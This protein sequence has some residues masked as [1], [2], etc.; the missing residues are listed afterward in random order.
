MKRIYYFIITG[1]FLLST[2]NIIAQD[3]KER[4]QRANESIVQLKSGA[5][6]VQLQSKQISIDVYIEKG[7]Q[8]IAEEI[9][10]EQK[11]KNIRIMKA[12]N[13]SFHFCEVYF[14]LS[15]QVDDLMNKNWDELVFIN[16]NYEKDLEIKLKESFYLI[17]VYSKTGESNKDS[18]YQAVLSFNAIIIVD[19]S[20]NELTKPFPYYLKLPEEIQKLKK[21]KK[22][23]YNYDKELRD[24][25]YWQP[26]SKKE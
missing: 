19:E 6:L 14:F 4:T 22:K 3:K 8:S 12:Y 9:A 23:I 7:Y 21:L 10:Q 1:I 16:E 24:F 26:V 15:D 5:L 17:A 20:F 11:E 25:Y 18:Q 13:E 2:Q